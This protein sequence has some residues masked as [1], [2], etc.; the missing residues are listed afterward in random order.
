MNQTGILKYIQ[1]THK[2]P[3][4][5]K[6]RNEKQNKNKWNIKLKYGKVSLNLIKNFLYCK[7]TFIK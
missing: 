2:Q 4:K 7:I 1:V 5:R 6:P 3:G